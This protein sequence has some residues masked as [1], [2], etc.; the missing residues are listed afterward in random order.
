MSAVH[1]LTDWL[2]GAEACF[3]AAK[4]PEERAAARAA[5]DRNR[6][7]L[8]LVFDA[9]SW[10]LPPQW[11]LNGA[12]AIRELSAAELLITIA[13]RRPVDFRACAG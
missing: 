4:T 5:I 13:E 2:R 1:V 8:D 10:F 12:T 6:H 11:H 3:A 7:R 9:Y